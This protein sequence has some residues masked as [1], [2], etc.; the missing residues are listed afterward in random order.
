MIRQ[1]HPRPRRGAR[2]IAPLGDVHDDDPL[3]ADLCGAP[4]TTTRTADGLRCPLC[5]AHAA[6]IDAEIDAGE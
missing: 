1:L 6:E 4:A 2:C 5:A 3:A